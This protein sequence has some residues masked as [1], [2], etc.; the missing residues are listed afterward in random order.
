MVSYHIIATSCTTTQLT[1]VF[2]TWEDGHFT[3]WVR[4]KRLVKSRAGARKLNV[5]LN[6]S[7][8]TFQKKSRKVLLDEACADVKRLDM[9]T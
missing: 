1:R 8:F 5:Q 4:W 3:Q 6:Q 2:G 7:T 9:K